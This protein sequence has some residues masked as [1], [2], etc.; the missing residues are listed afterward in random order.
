MKWL[1]TCGFMLTICTGFSQSRYVD[2][3]IRWVNTHS[4]NDSARILTLHRTSYALS[5]SD[6]EQSAKYY[7]QV[8][9]ISESRQFTYGRALAA[10]NLGLILSSTGNYERSSPSYFKAIEYADSCHAPRLKAIALNNIA[11]DFC[12]NGEYEKSREYARKAMALNHTLNAW[13]GV[14]INYELLHRDDFNE[15]KYLSA[16]LYLDTG[17]IYAVRADEKYIYSQFYVGYAKIFAI[18]GKKDSAALYFDK[19][20]KEAREMK[21]T[22]NVFHVYLS[23]AKYL[24]GLSPTAKAD[25][26]LKALFLARNTRYKKGIIEASELLSDVYQGLGQRDSA[27]AY[28]KMYRLNSDSVYTDHYRATVALNESKQKELE[29]RQQELEY[30]N[31]KD[32]ASIQE[33]QIGLKNVLLSAAVIGLVLSVL[34]AVLVYKSIG[35][36]RSREESAYKH[37]IAETEM[38]ALRAQ[39]NPHFFF[40]SLNSIENFIMHNEKKLASD[41]LN[42]FARFIRSILDSSTS[43]LIELGKD[44]ESLQLYIDLEQLRFGD[45]FRY[46]CEVDPEL[47]GGEFYVP[48]LLVQPFL[49]NAIIH[50]IGPSDRKDL[51][52]CLSVKRE[53]ERI[54]YTIE[55]N[56]IGREQSRAYLDLNKPMHK[57]VGMKITQER[58]NIFNGSAASAEPIRIT[59]LFDEQ[60]NAC[61][62]RI[63]FAIKFVS[64]ATL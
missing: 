57:S 8:N 50:G 19:A 63:E 15:G 10:I 27:L 28:Y 53:G 41:Y 39:M 25:L 14:A 40:N 54:A 5:E 44:L 43:E 49:E 6:V 38:Q 45:K 37:K 58:I 22:R 26:L 17:M 2:S 7:N 20:V 36:K 30:N 51:K 13:R 47:T 35:E 62:T 3:M 46:V 60:G 29:Y 52:I 18:A 48:S 64:N 24:G 33:K 21:D 11:D 59:D 12:T 23:E 56:G 16:R 4:L 31:L 32:L 9:E 61:G 34:V 1:I 42:K 55:D